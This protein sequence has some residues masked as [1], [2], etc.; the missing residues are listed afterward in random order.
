M[1]LSLVVAE[2]KRCP[3]MYTRWRERYRPTV[4]CA[5]LEY[6]VMFRTGATLWI[7]AGCTSISNSMVGGEHR[8]ELPSR[9]TLGLDW[10]AFVVCALPL[11]AVTTSAV[12]R[13]NCKKKSGLSVMEISYTALLLLLNCFHKIIVHIA[14]LWWMTYNPYHVQSLLRL[15]RMLHDVPYCFSLVRSQRRNWRTH[16]PCSAASAP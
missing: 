8:C 3:R 4:G 12:H 11:I 7:S 14:F 1:Q 2:S 16:A 13:T 9:T 10:P 6:C 15:R 5:D